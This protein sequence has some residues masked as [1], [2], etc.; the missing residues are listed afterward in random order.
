MKN[1]TDASALVQTGAECKHY[2]HDSCVKTRY[3]LSN[4]ARAAGKIVGECP[5]C[6]INYSNTLECICAKLDKIDNIELKIDAF[7]KKIDS[8]QEKIDKLATDYNGIKKSVK[9]LE[10]RVSKVEKERPDFDNNIVAEVKA[11]AQSIVD[12][13]LELRTL[14]LESQ[15]LA[16]EIILGGIPESVGEKLTDVVTKLTKKL[17]VSVTENEIVKAERLGRHGQNDRNI[18][19]KFNNQ[20]HVDSLISNIKGNSVKVGELLP[21]A[22]LPEAVVY[23]HRRHPTSLYKLRQDV[24]KKYPSIPPKDIWISYSSVNVRYA[25]DIPPVKLLPSAGLSPLQGLID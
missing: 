16:D 11:A 25:G 4:R 3:N 2:F 5:V 19:V 7:T 24:R 10:D 17:K 18:R 13:N 15:S 14:Q 22:E 1:V 20:R 8:M 23:M 12:S 9:L 21:D 6:P